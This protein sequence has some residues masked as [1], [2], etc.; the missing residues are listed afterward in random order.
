MDIYF[1][2]DDVF[3]SFLWLEK[4][5]AKTIYESFVFS[6]LKGLHEKYGISIDAYCIYRI[7]N[8]SLSDVSDRW[9]SEFCQCGDWLRFGFHSFTDETNYNESSSEEIQTHYE[10]MK[11]E[12]N[13]ITGCDCMADMIRLHYFSGNK[14]VARTLRNLGVHVLLTADDDRKSYGLQEKELSE[15][16]RTG[17]YYDKETDMMYYRTDFRVENME[18]DCYEVPTVNN[19][20]LCFFTHEPL[21][22]RR[23]IVTRIN[24]VLT[25]T[26]GE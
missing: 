18:N 13:R 17:T 14:T 5:N 25:K 23:D 22:G 15:L 24:D 10:I 11:H 20:R 6:T 19:G 21:L 7:G 12:I 3:G 8:R 9:K 16:N 2:V 4:T 26:V 1:S